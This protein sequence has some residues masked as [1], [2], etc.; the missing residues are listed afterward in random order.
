[1]LP[2]T[3]SGMQTL[4]IG[5]LVVCQMAASISFDIALNYQAKMGIYVARERNGICGC[6]S[7]TD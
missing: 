3:V 4:S 6:L 2:H 5:L 7:A 1:M